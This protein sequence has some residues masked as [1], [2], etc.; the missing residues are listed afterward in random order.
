MIKIETLIARAF[1]LDI[2]TIDFL[3][4]LNKKYKISRSAIIRTLLKY[5]INNENELIQ[6]ITR[7]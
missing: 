2:E 3:D 7:E 6:I 1:T 5:Y 4:D